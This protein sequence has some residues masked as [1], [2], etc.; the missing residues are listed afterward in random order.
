MLKIPHRFLKLGPVPRQVPHMHVHILNNASSSLP[1]LVGAWACSP[2]SRPQN[3]PAVPG[4]EPSTN[5][6][7]PR[8]P[9]SHPQTGPAETRQMTAAGGH[10]GSEFLGNQAQTCCLPHQQ[11]SSE[12]T[13][14][15]SQAKMS[16]LCFSGSRRPCAPQRSPSALAT[17]VSVSMNALS[18]PKPYS[19]PSG[20]CQRSQASQMDIETLRAGGPLLYIL[21]FEYNCYSLVV[22]L[23]VRMIHIV[24][25]NYWDT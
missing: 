13:L 22:N 18:P 17:P 6:R 23:K 2:S 21:N 8:T 3:Q 14:K 11:G 24:W 12:E 9:A 16:Q 7:G 10:P 19:P 15:T 20:R 1:S 4:T 25:E 5:T